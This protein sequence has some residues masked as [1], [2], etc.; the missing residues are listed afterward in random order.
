[1]EE[2]LKG[3]ELFSST[4]SRILPLGMLTSEQLQFRLNY[5]FLSLC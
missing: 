3:R 4:R 2:K 5:W 1:M